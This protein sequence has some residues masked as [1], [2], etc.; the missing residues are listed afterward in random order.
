MLGEDPNGSLHLDF[1]LFFVC[2]LFF[3]FLFCFFFL[4]LSPYP[5]LLLPL[6]AAHIFEVGAV[7]SFP[8]RRG[9]GLLKVGEEEEGEGGKGGG[10]DGKGDCWDGWGEGLFERGEEEG[11]VKGG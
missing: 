3:V 9:A 8:R 6:R 11:E 10:L 4:V 1:F 2:F 7:S 5:S